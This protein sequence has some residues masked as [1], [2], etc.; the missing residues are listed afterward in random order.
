MLLDRSCYDLDLI[1]P[2]KDVI[3]LSRRVA[4]ILGGAFYPLDQ[5]RQTARI[6]LPQTKGQA[7]VLDFAA[8]RAPD[9][10]GD[11][12]ARDFT[13]NAMAIDLRHPELLIDP[14][15]GAHDLMSGVLRICSER[16]LINDPLRS[17]RGVR[18]A[19]QFGLKILPQTRQRI[20]QAAPFLTNVSPERVRD[21][22]FH[23]L[24][25]PQP[26]TAMRLLEMLNLLPEVFP[27]L[28]PLKDISQSPPHIHNVWEHSV[29]VLKY[30][31][32][33]L[34]VLAITHN[35]EI[36]SNWRMG[37]VSLRLGR[38][39]S[40]IQKHLNKPL[41]GNRSR[42]ALLRLAALYHDS[43]K[44]ETRQVD[45][46]NRIRFIEHET[47]GERL[48]AQRARSY[49]L[50]NTEINLLKTIVGHHMRPLW[51]A[52]TGKP[53]SRRATYR[54]FRDCGDAGIDICLM[55]LADSLATYGPT[56]PQETWT[57]LLDTVRELLQSFWEE[58]AQKIFPPPLLTGNDLI[59]SFNLA[60]GPLIGQL[61]EA[62]RESQAA[63]EIL[64]QDQALAYAKQWLSGKQ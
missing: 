46:H 60:P 59:R 13:I 39:R 49:H 14:L 54:F 37:Y 40:Q 28:A 15:G 53:P 8:L 11:L 56:M 27:E 20:R 23:I 47:V 35:P 24:E 52:Q 44:I 7:K 2:H 55:A 29:N 19:V 22:L 16:S 26:A 1:L 4:N 38:Y 48:I 64:D 36:T 10:D 18:M 50:S 42:P 33:I 51:L 17:L 57:G 9:L 3:N 25:S 30:L 6:I 62:L 12:H 45:Q 41:S 63:G 5:E 21:E 32:Q 31:D 43:G 34:D 61:L 58:P